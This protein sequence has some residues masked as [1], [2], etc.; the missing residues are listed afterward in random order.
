MLITRTVGKKLDIKSG[1]WCWIELMSNI[2]DRGGWWKVGHQVQWVMIKFDKW[3]WIKLVSNVS[4]RG[5]WRKVGHQVRWVTIKFDKWHW[6]ELVSNISDKDRQHIKFVVVQGCL[7]RHQGGWWWWW[8]RILY[9]TL[10]NISHNDSSQNVIDQVG[11][12]LLGTKEDGGNGV[13]RRRAIWVVWG[14]CDIGRHWLQLCTQFKTKCCWSV[15]GVP[16]WALR[17]IVVMVDSGDSVARGKSHRCCEV[18]VMLCDIG[19]N[20][21]HNSS[22]NDVDWL[23]AGQVEGKREMMDVW[24][25]VGAVEPVG[26]D[27][28]CC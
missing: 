20:C 6:I 7:A 2:S 1:E 24:R 23:V 17:R 16:C 11:G 27:S 13:V 21:T 10:D 5:S 3:R 8:S 12:A 28:N 26:N 18:F 9:A 25:V 15:W 14:I 19:H 22:Q 4:D